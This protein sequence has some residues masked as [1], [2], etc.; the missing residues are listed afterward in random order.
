MEKAIQYGC[1]MFDEFSK[2]FKDNYGELAQVFIENKKPSALVDKDNK[3]EVE[4]MHDAYV[5]EMKISFSQAL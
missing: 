2:L 1:T 3:T 5:N 4:N